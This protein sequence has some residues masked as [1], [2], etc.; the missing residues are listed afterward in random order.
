MAELAYRT[1][2]RIAAG[3]YIDLL[4][5][6]TLGARRPIDR[7]DVIAGALEGSDVVVTAWDGPLLV[8]AARAITDFHLH[9]YLADLCVDESYQRQGIGLE[10]QRVLRSLLG[11]LCKLKLSAAPAAAEYYPRVGY[12]RNDRAWELPPGRPL[13]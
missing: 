2:R 9:C 7:P 4:G 10:L 5:R 13:A 12:E 8:G 6:S 11:P 3:E 1:D